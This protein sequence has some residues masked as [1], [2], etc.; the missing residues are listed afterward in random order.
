MNAL[1]NSGTIASTRPGD[2]GTAAA[3]VDHSGTLALVQNNGAI[4]DHQAPTLAT[5]GTAIDLSANTSGA[6][7]R[8][9]A[10]AQGAPAR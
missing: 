7:V 9:I 1:Y 5:C 6:I 4:G 10:A 3:I 8:Q 2:S